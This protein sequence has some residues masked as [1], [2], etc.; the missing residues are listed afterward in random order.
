M[1]MAIPLIVALSAPLLLALPSGDARGDERPQVLSM[2]AKL[3]D[4]LARL[5]E[6]EHNPG[7][8]RDLVVDEKGA[9]YGR[10]GR[11]YYAVLALWYRDSPAKNTDAG[12]AFTRRAPKGRWT[13]AMVD[14]AYDPCARPAPEPLMRAWH[15]KVSDCLAP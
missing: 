7:R 8:Y 10:V 2:S 9:H 14:G 5:F 11:R 3:R 6:R 1:R 15:M 12:T 4:E 13:V